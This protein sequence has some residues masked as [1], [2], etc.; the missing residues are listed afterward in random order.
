[1]LKIT[2]IKKMV[3]TDLKRKLSKSNK[4]MEKPGNDQK[5]SG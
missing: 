1:M 5:Y 4:L 3:R 2:S